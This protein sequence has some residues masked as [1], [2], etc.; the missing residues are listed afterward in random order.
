M[1][2]NFMLMYTCIIKVIFLAMYERTSTLFILLIFAC[3]CVSEGIL[4][5][6]LA[7]FHKIFF[8]QSN[9]GSIFSLPPN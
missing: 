3:M 1:F 4:A 8:R 2:V 5:Y 7:C 9:F 6:K